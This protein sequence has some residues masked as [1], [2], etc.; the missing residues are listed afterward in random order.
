MVN[1]N[2]LEAEKK[3]AQEEKEGNIVEAQIEVYENQ[4][5]E[6]RN[7]YADAKAKRGKARSKLPEEIP[8]DSAYK[9]KL[10]E[11]QYAKIQAVT[12]KQSDMA[13]EYAAEVKVRQKAK[14]DIQVLDRE[15]PQLYKKAEQEVESVKESVYVT[16]KETATKKQH[17]QQMLGIA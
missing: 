1:L 6:A 4:N 12:Q 13:D 10:L 11:A 17:L 2:T 16:A 7:A 9:E 8:D 15:L 14:E 5:Y 3:K